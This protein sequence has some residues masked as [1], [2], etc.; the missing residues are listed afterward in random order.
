[1]EDEMI[2]YLTVDTASMLD[3]WIASP[4]RKGALFRL[5]SPD[6]DEG[7]AREAEPSFSSTLAR[8]ITS[9][10]LNPAETADMT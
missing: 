5:V 1:M 3:P 2:V 6:E 8:N 9:R 7:R 4:L 10:A